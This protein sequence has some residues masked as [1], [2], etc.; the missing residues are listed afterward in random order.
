MHPLAHLHHHF[1][2]LGDDLLGMRR[3]LHLLTVGN[4]PGKGLDRDV[5]V[6]IARPTLAADDENVA[7]ID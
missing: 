3:V 4:L 5:T 7:S 1:L 6:G 2:H